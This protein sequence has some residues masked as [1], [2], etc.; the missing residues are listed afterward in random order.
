L[1]GWF[2]KNPY[3]MSTSGLLSVSMA[4]WRYGSQRSMCAVVATTIGM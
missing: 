4:V 1:G 3:I 2:E